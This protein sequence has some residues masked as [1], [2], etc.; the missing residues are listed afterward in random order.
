MFSSA[1][2]KR[3]SLSRGKTQGKK[4]Q[5]EKKQRGKRGGERERERE[6]GTVRKRRRRKERG[7]REITLSIGATKNIEESVVSS[8]RSR[9]ARRCRRRR[10]LL[11]LLLLLCTRAVIRAS[12]SRPRRINS[13]FSAPLLRLRRT[14]TNEATNSS[15]PERGIAPSASRTIDGSPLSI[16]DDRKTKPAGKEGRRG[17]REGGGVGIY[18]IVVAIV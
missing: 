6:R 16:G 8:F 4:K 5:G 12:Y 13:S 2:R 11:L 10:P 17:R 1:V 3:V 18:R 7:R 14:A 9:R 15:V